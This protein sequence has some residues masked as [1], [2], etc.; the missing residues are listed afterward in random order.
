M[1]STMR[2]FVVTEPGCGLV[3][4]VA[5]PTAGAGQ[6]VIEVERVGLCGTDVELFSGEMAYVGQG[7]THYPLRIGHEW[8][9]TVI[10]VGSD[11]DRSWIGRRVM[12]DTMIGDGTC[13]RC[14]RGAHHVCA[15]RH[16]VGIRDG[17]D[18]ALA[19]KVVV[20]VVSLHALPDAIDPTLGA[21]VE[22]GGNAWRAAAATGASKGDRVLVMGPGT[23]GLLTAMFLR[24]ADVEVH[25]MGATADSIAYARQ[26]G[27]ENAWMADDLPD[28]P[29]D[30][31]VDAATDERLPA[32]AIER[33]EP[34]GT[35][36]FIGL[37]HGPSLIDTR[38]LL[39]NDL[40]ATGILSAS[41]G[42]EPTIRAYASGEFDPRVLV[43]ATLGMGEAA[44]ILSG[45]R[46]ESA[47]P[48]P[49]IHIDP[50]TV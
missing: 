34:G 24:A 45:T 13:R 16:E 5:A 37:G 47:G 4:E 18:G 14:R 43:A 40:T 42:L 2:A 36:V 9:G 41:P 44:A 8:C 30:S 26:L 10:G 27:F 35:V 1:N 17:C 29:F 46:P 33:V 39:L 19:E 15:H 22:P 48:G 12:G 20:P 31:V 23:I 28:V 6:A 21:L 49:K 3:L 25:L 50:R 32:F 11:V 7:H 38:T